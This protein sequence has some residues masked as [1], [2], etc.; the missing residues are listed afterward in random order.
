M[1][2]F[3]PNFSY[4]IQFCI[5]R[6][7]IPTF[8]TNFWLHKTQI[9]NQEVLYKNKS[10]LDVVG[11][12]NQFNTYSRLKISPKTAFTTPNLNLKYIFTLNKDKES[13]TALKRMQLKYYYYIF[14]NHK[15]SLTLKVGT[16]R[17]NQL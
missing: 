10:D 4:E 9:Q 2:L 1:S 16:I 11:E 13:C 7:L 12:F 3:F 17:K 6:A 15:S 14:S 8:N 5:L